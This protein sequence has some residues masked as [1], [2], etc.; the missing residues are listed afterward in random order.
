MEQHSLM[1]TFKWSLSS[2]RLKQH[3]LETMEDQKN[4]YRFMVVEAVKDLKQRHQLYWL[5]CRPANWK[6]APIAATSPAWL[7][8]LDI[9]MGNAGS[10]D[11]PLLNYDSFD[12]GKLEP[13]GVYSFQSGC[14]MRTIKRLILDRKLAP[15]YEGYAS[16]SDI[17]KSSS[18]SSIE[19]QSSKIKSNSCIL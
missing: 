19:S 4:K 3:R 1:L 7:Q 11:D 13:T 17:P 10:K 16:L 12:G 15:F 14:D 2:S 8:I 18:A 6:A 5:I 9:R